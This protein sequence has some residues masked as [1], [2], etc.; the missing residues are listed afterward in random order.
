M[1]IL[2]KLAMMSNMDV[3]PSD[4]EMQSPC[5]RRLK[6]N[7]KI[8]TDLMLL[9]T[10]QELNSKF[11]TSNP[12]LVM[13]TNTAAADR[14]AKLDALVSER[15]SLPECLTFNCQFCPKNNPTTPV[16]VFAPVK[17]SNSLKKD[18][19]DDNETK[20]SVK[21]INK[22]KKKIQKRKQKKDS[23]EDFVFP[24]KTVRP[25]SP[26]ISEPIATANSFSDLVEDQNKVTEDKEAKTADIPKPRPS[27]PIHLKIKENIFRSQ[28]KS[29][30]QK[31]PDTIT[32]NSGKF[33]KLYTKDVDV[34][35]KLTQFLE[36][37]EEEGFTVDNV[38]QLISK[39]HKGPLP[40]FQI[41]LPR[42]AENS[43]IFDLKTLGYL[44]V[45]V[46]GFLVRGITQC[47]NCNNFFHTASECHLKPRCLKC[48]NEHPAKQCPIKERQ[49][50]PFCIN[51]QEY[52]H[53]ACYTK[54][55]QLPKPKKGSP[56]P[57]IQNIN[58]NKCKEGVTFANVVSGTNFPPLPTP[59]ATITVIFR[60]IRP[61]P[62]PEIH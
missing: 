51:C 44:Q 59:N 52:G 55:P 45:R 4:D 5:F 32:K 31:F 61:R 50:N 7:R 20:T 54:C 58:N 1:S 19:I 48:G 18:N 9:K 36:N 10:Y 40:F 56:L 30:L 17:K 38:T 23:V 53:T 8:D 62:L 57:I 26:S 11:H 47:F 39:K 42:N 29:I 16:E 6:I 34:K 22:N 49:D 33:V 37:L 3:D 27:Q 25:A 13:T 46:E 24:K 35:H 43:K 60:S 15:D 28:I 2:E 21:A 14:K 41:T 12:S